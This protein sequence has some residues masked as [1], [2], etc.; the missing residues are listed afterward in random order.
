VRSILRGFLNVTTISFLFLSFCGVDKS[1][2]IE[3]S[4]LSPSCVSWLQPPPGTQGCG[5][6]DEYSSITCDLS[7]CPDIPDEICLKTHITVCNP[8]EPCGTENGDLGCLYLGA[9]PILPN[10]NSDKQT[11]AA[12]SIISPS[13]LSLG[14][15][16][17][18]VGT[19]FSLYYFTNHTNGRDRTLTIPLQGSTVDSD[20]DSVTAQIQIAGQSTT[21]SFTPSANLSYTY[22]WNG[23]DSSGNPVEGTSQATVTVTEHHPSG[24]ADYPVISNFSLGNWNAKVIGLGAWTLNIHHFYDANSQT[25]YFGYGGTRSVTAIAV[26]GGGYMVTSSDGREVYNFDSNGNH[27]STLNGLTGATLYTFAYDGSGHL[28][29]VTDAFSNV[30]TFTYASGLL[31]GITAPHGQA[32]SVT[33][34]TNGFLATVT[35]PNSEVYTMTYGSTGLI[36]SFEKPNGKTNSFTYDSLGN[37]ATDSSNSGESKTLSITNQTSS[38]FDVSI[39][40]AMSLTATYTNGSSPGTPSYYNIGSQG[41]NSSYS[42]INGQTGVNETANYGNSS[43]NVNYTADP[44]FSAFASY[45]SNG[46]YTV[47]SSSVNFTKTKT[48]SGGTTPYNFTSLTTQTTINSNT[49]TSVYT[50]SN[51]TFSYTTPASRTFSRVINSQGQTTSL[52][53]P[54]QASVSYSY[55]ANGR[56]HQITQSSRTTTLSYLTSG[57]LG[58]I[59]NAASQTTS[60]TYDNAGRVSQETLPDTRAISF[61]YDADGNVTSVTPPSTSAHTFSTNLFDLIAQY[62]PPTLTGGSTNTTYTYD[63]DGHL[64]QITRPDTSTLTMSWGNN[65]NSI[66]DSTTSNVW[67]LNYSYDA[68][69][70]AMSPDG[71]Y[72][73]CGG[74]RFPTSCSFIGGGTYAAQ[75]AMTYDG[76]LNL[77]SFALTD[78]NNNVAPTLNFTYDADNIITGAG[79]ETITPDATTG[80]ITATALGSVN[81]A[82]T[83]DSTYGEEASF[84]ATY[85]TRSRS[86]INAKSKKQ[87]TRTP[88]SLYSESFIRD[89]LGRITT[90][91]E[92]EG[93]TTNTFVYSYDTSGRLSTVTKNS[94]AYSSY[95]YDSNSNRT[96]GTQGGTSFTATYDAQDR[97]ATFNTKTYTFDAN[98]VLQSVSDSSTSPASVTSYTYDA[99]G[100]LK[101]VTLPSGD[102]ISYTISGLNQRFQKSKNSVV[103]AEFVYMPD[104]RRIAAVLDSSGNLKSQFVYGVKSNVPDYMINGGNTYKIVSDH[105]GSVRMVVDTST[106]TIAEQIDYDDFG[107][108]ISDTSPGFQPFGFAGCLYD[109]DTHLCRFGARDYDASIGRWT[110][111]DPTLFFNGGG[112]NLYGYTFADPINFVDLSGTS[113]R[114]VQTITNTFNNSVQAMTNAG[115]RT[116][117]GIWNNFSS[118]LNSATGGALGH[119]YQGCYDQANT[120]QTA[121]QSQSY[122]DQ[123]SFSQTGSNGPHLQ[124]QSPLG[125]NLLPHWWL[126][127]TSS[128]PTDP[129]LIIDPYNNTIMNK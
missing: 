22:T 123:W 94:S 51:N 27:T 72:T 9:S 44:R 125:I 95:T 25:V 55:D 98:G 68:F 71:N 20:T 107:N 35:N 30:T 16:I 17:Q 76:N 50:P 114:D 127:G 65:I 118:S 91:T 82:Y 124:P 45:Q 122:D 13:N 103:K 53:L 79:S 33:L 6:H 5:Y 3:T 43:R 70:Y 26:V 86:R 60:F 14:E 37:L 120:V 112:V 10:F 108:V 34:D 109:H 105:L 39:T 54:G 110:S 116:S 115:E 87:L 85:G 128:N 46:S 18:I 28:S 47:D 66:T 83:Y 24:A 11:C 4:G 63:N 106:G 49:A 129:V 80:K 69:S 88:T 62:I 57:F 59:Q 126:T 38:E 32:T 93:A 58:S 113:P 81:E 102:V 99:L 104:N 15:S 56:L 8:G 119:S 92:T 21:Q 2:A 74:I 111:K 84:A 42:S 12:G 97:I 89:N 23:N 78:T 61:G 1:L 73:Y 96:S 36:T 41:F 100:N 101:S 64:T 29:T 48:V 19:P 31:T 90:K 117:P 67:Y 77:S 40:D 121:L 7:T 52:S 75:Q